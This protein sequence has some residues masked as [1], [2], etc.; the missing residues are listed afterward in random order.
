M[1]NL[2]GKRLPRRCDVINCVQRS[3]KEA[4]TGLK[5]VAYL[6]VGIIKNKIKSVIKVERITESVED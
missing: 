5:T 3:I 4:K 1:R 6:F 2:T